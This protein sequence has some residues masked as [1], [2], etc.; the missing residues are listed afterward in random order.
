MQQSGSCSPG[1]GHGTEN[2]L[3]DSFLHWAS[4]WGNWSVY[5]CD[6][7]CVTDTVLQ[8]CPAEAVWGCLPREGLIQSSPNSDFHWLG[9]ESG[10]FH[11]PAWRG[12]FHPW[13]AGRCSFPQ[14]LIPSFL[15]HCILLERNLP[16]DTY[17][18]SALLIDDI[19]ALPVFT[20]ESN[21]ALTSLC[22][23]SDLLSFAQALA[24]V[25]CS[26]QW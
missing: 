13:A 21:H 1:Q 11:P 25:P 12:I 10:L 4:D 2:E 22:V 8:D 17:R 7:E 16:T 20:K 26:E 5:G 14:C 6:T 15:V 9:S 18:F 24:E 23:G 3:T 19:S